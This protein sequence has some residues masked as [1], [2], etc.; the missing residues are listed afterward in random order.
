MPGKKG[1]KILKGTGVSPGISLGK[2]FLYVHEMLIAP[3]P[4]KVVDLEKEI[5]LYEGSL[6]QAIRDLK[7][8]QKKAKFKGGEEAASIFDAHFLI[9][10]D[11]VLKSEIKDFITENRVNASYAVS[12]VMKEYQSVLENSENEY[13]SQRAFDLEDVCRR[14]VRN[15]MFS[16]N[17]PLDYNKHS[18][19][20][21]VVSTNIFP[22]DAI[23]LNR[24][25]TL[26]F[27]TEYGG[28]ASHTAILSRSMGIP[29]IVGVAGIIAEISKCEFMIIDGDTGIV[30]LDPDSQT[31]TK[32]KALIDERRSRFKEID[33]KLIGSKSFTKDGKEIKIAYN[34]QSDEELGDS[35][36]YTSEGVGL[37][38]TEFIFEKKTGLLTENEQFEIYN[39]IAKAVSPDKFTIRLLDIGGDKLLGRFSSHEDNPFLGLRGIRLLFK[40]KDILIPHIRAILRTA[41]LNKAVKLLIPFVTTVDEVRKL[42]RIIGGVQERLEGEG[43]EVNHDLEIGVMLEIP[44]AILMADR[45]SKYCDFFSIGSNDLTQ[46]T[47]AT[48]R[49]NNKVTYLYDSLDPSVLMLIKQAV[50]SSSKSG[51]FISVCGLMASIPEAVPILIGLGIYNISVS[52]PSLPTIKNLIYNLD[53][54]EC[55]KLVEKCLK[56]DSYQ[57]IKKE[58]KQF[59][60]ENNIQI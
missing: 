43:Y 14:V 23:G 36:K 50:Q 45:I 28:E 27:V 51:K 55:V 57:K 30:I 32:F 60:D 39:K 29:A 24:K 59:F 31:I 47:L 17:R 54:S 5:S 1:E 21:L 42:K 16:E 2:P 7:S 48:D 41:G 33:K 19:P 8:D 22:S 37:F 49:G 15:L 58:I 44:S 10:E 4:E 56:L 20:S 53:L 35:K 52:V 18:E 9:L 46:Y 38:R 13:L 25:N 40:R 3:E 12:K 26:G 11:E 6:K 34:I